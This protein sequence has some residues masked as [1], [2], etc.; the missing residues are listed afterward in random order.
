MSR[1]DNKKPEF[2]SMEMV[3]LAFQKGL[4]RASQATN[5]ASKHDPN[6]LT[7]R[8]ALFAVNSLDVEL[9]AGLKM[10]QNGN[11]EVEDRIR[12]D[13]NAPEETRSLL[14]FTVEPQPLDPVESPCVLLSRLDPLT[15]GDNGNNFLVWVIDGENRV[16]AEQDV[17]L[18]FIPAGGRKKAREVKTKTDLTGQLK[19]NIDPVEGSYHSTTVFKPRNFTLDMMTDWVVSAGTGGDEPIRSIELP[20]YSRRMK[21]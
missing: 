1:P 5:D 2:P 16:V 3:V 18:L 20:V 15:E 19:F 17:S 21:K 9:R 6:F 10:V 7:G 11:G 4:A 14:K 8:R 13:F 12:V